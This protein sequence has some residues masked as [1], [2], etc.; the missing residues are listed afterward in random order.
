MSDP[1]FAVNSC[2]I[3]S[4]YKDR[5]AKARFFGRKQGFLSLLG[6]TNS[7]CCVIV[8]MEDEKDMLKGHHRATE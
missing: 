7:C 4:K 2:N 8:M 3:K 5:H 1:K 6:L